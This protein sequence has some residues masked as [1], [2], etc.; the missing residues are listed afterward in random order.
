M[1]LMGEAVSVKAD[2]GRASVDHLAWSALDIFQS[3]LE[4][5][6]G[7]FSN[8]SLTH[9]MTAQRSAP[10]GPTK[11]AQLFLRYTLSITFDNIHSFPFTFTC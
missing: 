10:D 2:P 4:Y 1:E 11:I 9:W 3:E 7:I 5:L 6:L 8:P